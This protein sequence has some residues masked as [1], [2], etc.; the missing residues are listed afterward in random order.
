M[1]LSEY[2]CVYKTVVQSSVKLV[3]EAPVVVGA[4]VESADDR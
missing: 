3:A 1:T 2:A 4:A